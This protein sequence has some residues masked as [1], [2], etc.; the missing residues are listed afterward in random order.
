LPELTKIVDEVITRLAQ[1]AEIDVDV[2]LQIE[3]SH[4][5]EG[6]T[7]ETIRTITENSRQ[8]KVRGEWR[9]DG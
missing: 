2:T 7:D 6:F 4:R 1:D 3:A 5:G 8:L 9:K